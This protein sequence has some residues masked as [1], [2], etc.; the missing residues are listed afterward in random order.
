MD[1]QKILIIFL[2]LVIIAFSI[3]TAKNVFDSYTKSIFDM[4]YSKGYTDAVND[5]IKSAEDESCEVFSVYNN[6]KEVNL[7]NID[8]LYE[9]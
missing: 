4:S 7:I 5:L 6:D 3:Y 2:F 1:K 8:C 9:E